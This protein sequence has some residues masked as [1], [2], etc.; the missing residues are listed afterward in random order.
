VKSR[1]Q[2]LA[3]PAGQL[4]KNDAREGG[5]AQRDQPEVPERRSN[6]SSK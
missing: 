6:E 3:A 2:P 1:A 5:E 4:M